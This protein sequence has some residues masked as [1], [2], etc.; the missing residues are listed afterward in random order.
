MANINNGKKEDQQLN[1]EQL[2]QTINKIAP[3]F[4]S[5]IEDRYNILRVIDFLQPIGRRSLSNKLNI[6]ERTTRSE[7]T[8]LKEQGLIEITTDGMNTTLDGKDTIEKLSMLFHDLKGLKTLEK[9][10]KEIIG[11]KKVIVVPGSLDNDSLVLK[12]I[13]KM[14]SKYI[15]EKIVNGSV[16]GLTGG[17][18]ISHVIREFKKE[19]E[20]LDETTVVPARGGLGKKVEFQANT[21]VENLANKIGCKYKALYTPDSL[22]KN[23]IMSL[24]NEPSI[25]EIM[26]L[27]EKL[28]ILVFGVGR[29]DIMAGRRGLSKDII[30]KLHKNNAVSEAF[31]YY[32][33]DE[34]NIVHEIS[35]IGINLKKFKSLK[36]AIAV[37]AGEEKTEAIISICKL[38][39]NLVLITDEG[40]AN[41]IILKYKEE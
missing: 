14:A 39:K 18:T 23:T 22:S 16:I 36:N 13:G 8:L 40:V 21:L 20:K 33:N 6:T 31:G 26:D 9:R 3:N 2:I 17:T 5:Q 32:F 28:D 38:N 1:I 37:A 29:A 19:K 12:D 27:I 24:K 41:N 15:K 7:A 30:E 35:T 34:G 11:I 25:K 4:I 10:V